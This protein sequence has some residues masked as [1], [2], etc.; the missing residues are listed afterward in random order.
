MLDKVE[1]EKKSK[2]IT[3]EDCKAEI[4]ALKE[5]LVALEQRIRNEK[6]PV[7]VLFEGW[8]ASGKGMVIGKTINCLD[9]RS[10]KV[11]SI[12]PSDERE[13]RMP[14]MWRF[15]NVIPEKGKLCI[16]DRSWYQEIV[17]ICVE[18][19]HPEEELLEKMDKFNTFERQLFDDGYAIIKIFLHIGRDEQKKRFEKLSEKKSTKWRVKES[20]LK[21]NK[22]YDSYFVEYDKMLEYT[23]TAYAPWTVID[24]ENKNATVAAVFRTLIDE[25]T[26]RLD[27]QKASFTKQELKRE[28]SILRNLSL[29]QIDLNKT[30]EKA[31]YKKEIKIQQKRLARLHGLLY[32]KKIPVVICFEGWDAAGKGGTIRRIAAGLDP[33]GYEAVP[34]SAPEP[35]ELNRHYLWRFWQHLPKTGH[36]AIF[37]R[38]WYGR[39]LVERIEGYTSENRWKKA[40]NEINEFENE[41]SESGVLVLK[42][43]IHIDKDEQLKRFNQRM[44]TPEKRWKITDEDWRNRDKWEAYELAANQMFSQTSTDFA[45]WHIIENNCKEYGRIQALKT[46]N[47]SIEK[48][49]EIHSK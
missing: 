17:P 49:I 36:I 35:H 41:L 9:P 8:G 24:A 46:V 18:E 39:V 42:F 32:E 23:N 28:Y 7:L 25:I 48:W 14:F 26:K 43:W 15:W 40:F 3:K 31:E 12:V 4:D 37:D 27:N 38:T 13:K 1:I 5:Q 10:F 45:P 30:I 19:K 20:D 22:K 21:R 29:A 2:N 44:N 6:L 34:V 16:L 11:H 33:R 47:D